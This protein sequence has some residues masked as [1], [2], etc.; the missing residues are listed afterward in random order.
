MTADA[1]Q[2]PVIFVRSERGS[3]LATEIHKV[4]N[5]AGVRL[6]DRRELA[7]WVLTLSDEQ[8]RR[9]VLSVGVSGK[10]QEF[11]LQYSVDFTLTAAEEQP[12]IDTQ[13]LALFRDY[14]FTGSDVLA[15]DD[16]EEMLY[17]GM[18]H[19]AAEII[20]R[21]L[22][23]HQDTSSARTESGV[24]DSQPGD[25]PDEAGRAL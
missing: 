3:A 11:E 17:Q 6:V 21:R 1:S 10:V 19:Q 8:R 12:V 20:L 13:T 25:D 7:A 23:I 22:L 4:F 2:L 15:K 9:R 14:S 24:Q 5:Q 16:E 18:Q